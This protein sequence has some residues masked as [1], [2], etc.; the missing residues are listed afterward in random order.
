MAILQT[1]SATRLRASSCVKSYSPE[2]GWERVGGCLCVSCV[3]REN[4]EH[5]DV[6]GLFGAGGWPRCRSH[7]AQRPQSQLWHSPSICFSSSQSYSLSS[8]SPSCPRRGC[9]WILGCLLRGLLRRVAVVLIIGVLLP[10]RPYCPR[11][12]CFMVLGAFLHYRPCP[13]RSCFGIF[14]V[15]LPSRKFCTRRSCF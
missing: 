3:R 8:A 9:F 6:L 7:R 2:V 11:R 13:C 4:N 10:S 14:G 5:V 1:D 12:S 15:P